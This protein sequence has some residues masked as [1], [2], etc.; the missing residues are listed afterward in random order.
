MNFFEFLRL[1]E[2]GGVYRKPLIMGILN[3]TPDSFSDGGKF[4]AAGLGVAA[5][6]RVDV[7]GAGADKSERI[8]VDAAVAHALQMAEE[9]AEII[10]IGGESSGPGSKDVSLEEE[11]ARVI[12]VVK[13]LKEV[14]NQKRQKARN[15]FL[16]GKAEN[17]EKAHGQAILDFK[18]AIS[19][20]DYGEVFI[21]VDTYKAEVA[22]EAIEAGADIINDVTALRGEVDAAGTSK[23]AAVLAKYPHVPVIIMYSKDPTARTTRENTQYDDVI[24][25]VRK[26][27]EERISYGVGQGIARGRFIVDPGM[28]AFVSTDPKYSLEILRRLREFGTDKVLKGLPI[29]IG[30]SRKGFIGQV[31][32]ELA[33]AMNGE[34]ESG[35]I[36]AKAGALPLRADQRLEGSLACAAIAMQNGASIL[37]VHD[38]KETRRFVDMLAATGAAPLAEKNEPQH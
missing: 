16:P 15:E 6:G 27:L 5:G 3:V 25:T 1:R 21:S 20:D 24:A 32:G 7:A 14:L 19:F 31:L 23:M 36:S 12:P 4:V 29:L 33:G 2:M 28:G 35:K 13:R 18:K 22:R 30:A 17:R 9:G 38:V 11:L 10:D 26:F 37:R 34:L 8:D